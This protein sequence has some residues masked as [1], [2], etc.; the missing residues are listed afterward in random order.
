M[1]AL[2]IWILAFGFA[3]SP[4]IAR[5]VGTGDDKDS[6][7]ANKKVETSKVAT[8]KKAAD[9]SKTETPA[10]PAPASVDNQL[11]QLRE[12]LEAQSRQLQEQNDAL[13]EQRKE[14]E[15]MR[16][17]LKAVNAPLENEG[18]VPGSNLASD[19][20]AN[21]GLG[22]TSNASA[23]DKEEPPTSIHIKGITLTPGGFFAAETVWRQR[24]I[25]NDVNTDFKSIPLPGQSQARLSEFNASG[26][27]SRISMKV[28]G[29]LDNVKLTGYYE[30]DFL[31]AGTTS[32]YN[33]S[34]SFTLRQ[35]QFWAQAAFDSGWKITGGQMWSL[36][37]ETKKG[38]DNLTEAT[39]L[40]IDAQYTA[41]FSW[42][43][44]YGLRVS[45]N[46]GDRFWLGVS[47]ENSQTTLGGKIQNDSTLIAAPGDLGGLLN[48][49]ANF[50]FN[51]TPDFI[52]KA[53]WEPGFGGH[54]EVFGIVS[55][56][57]SRI[58][59]CAGAS[60][61]NPCVVDLSTAPSSLGATNDTKTGGGIGANARWSLFSKK[62]D[63]GI[64]FLDGDGV[65]RYG[66]TSLADVTVHPD[67]TLEP[68]HSYQAL[69]SIELH[70]NPKWDIYAYAGG[71]Y[72]GRTAYTF[73]VP[74]TEAVLGVG[75][76][77][78]LLS[79]GGCLTEP[80]PGNQNTPGSLG[81][82]QQDIR[83]IIEGTIGFWN[84]F[85][86]GPK[87]TVQWG[88]QYSYA[89]RNTWSSATGGDP[90]GIDNMF[91]TS[92]RYYLP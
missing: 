69:G 88:L 33:Q 76:G 56:F 32:N 37:T 65:G 81:G 72:D 80:V 84:R 4:A 70:P 6:T 25:T 51:E 13:K 12:L 35:R 57:R 77:S 16:E 82:C 67:G 41:G 87:G 85:Y 75:Y 71:E 78:P 91:F 43:R 26:R 54:Y 45:K 18:A 48:N 61:N 2:A 34:N 17:N 24:G 10:T 89:V 63:L 60:V 42:M 53:A 28:E 74:V 5:T 31:S 19:P 36:A 27:Q 86:K 20:A 9:A 21:A 79:N 29:K 49:Q 90:H 39:P 59:P 68:I 8:D 47:M 64:H 92:F 3:A 62:F 11:Q 46:I 22:Y 73:T 83:N 58:F 50:S 38:L 7:A 1:R 52:V 40:T 66:T 14:M 44:Q 30:T 15:V 55:T 23:A